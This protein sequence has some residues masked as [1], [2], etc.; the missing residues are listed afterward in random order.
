MLSISK[1]WFLTKQNTIFGSSLST[2]MC[3]VESS[4]LPSVDLNTPTYFSRQ[5]IRN[6]TNNI[7]FLNVNINLDLTYKKYELYIKTRQIAHNQVTCMCLSGFTWLNSSTLTIHR[8]KLHKI[9][10]LNSQMRNYTFYSH[11]YY[12]QKDHIAD[13][14]PSPKSNMIIM[15]TDGSHVMPFIHYCRVVLIARRYVCM[16]S[17]TLENKEEK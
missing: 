3:R 14:Y 1:F 4:A 11:I 17:K 2:K 5:S 15:N 7:T 9:L 16:T 10:K 6:L 13:T 8:S 12:C